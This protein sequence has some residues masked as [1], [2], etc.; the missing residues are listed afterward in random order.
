LER[1]RIARDR[2]ETFAWGDWT[3]SIIACLWLFWF[4]Y[5]LRS[6]FR[7]HRSALF[8]L[9][10]ISAAA[11]DTARAEIADCI[12]ATCRIRHPLP[13]GRADVGTGTVIRSD[14]QAVL[15]LTAAHVTGRP[16]TDEALTVETWHR[17]CQSRPFPARCVWRSY[18]PT[19]QA[20]RDVALVSVDPAHFAGLLPPAMPL[21]D[22]D[23]AAGQTIVTVGCPSA[24]WPSAQVGHILMTEQGQGAVAKFLPIPEGGR[25]GSA[26]FDQAG[27]KI[28]GLLAWA[29]AEPGN[30]EPTH[31]L[32][33]RAPEVWAALRGARPLAYP[34]QEPVGPLVA[35]G[36]Q[37]EASQPVQCEGPYCWRPRRPQADPPQQPEALTPYP[38]LTPGPER[39]PPRT[40]TDYATRDDLAA[41]R[42][43]LAA[44]LAALEGQTEV[45]AQAAR[46]AAH[47]AQEKAVAAAQAAEQAQAQAVEAQQ[48]AADA[49]E[50]GQSRL[51]IIAAD[52]QARI[53]QAKAEGQTDAK[54]IALDVAKDALIERTPTIA[55]TLTGMLG[56]STPPSLAILAAA[57]LL[58]RRLRRRF[59]RDTATSQPASQYVQP[60]VYT[61]PYAAAPE[62]AAPQP[63]RSATQPRR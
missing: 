59:A 29:A 57:Y 4:L 37:A 43:E 20:Y 63:F 13:G 39:D 52:L 12:A 56:L 6:A 48:T 17:G 58:R 45:E 32:A 44:R 31:G 9:V 23:L 2:P 34:V 21:G 10:A 14:A 19:P 36:R 5:R 55:G 60:A 40:A 50:A 27:T 26:L 24:A 51:A 28:V 18:L 38:G 41:V 62:V 54:A 46:D 53:E 1:D 61:T 15:I 22:D 3:I 33:M 25:S 7:A 11:G 35:V 16:T 49:S 8:L 47:D 42:A 30:I